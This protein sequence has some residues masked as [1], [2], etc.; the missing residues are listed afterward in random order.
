[1]GSSTSIHLP[2]IA[3]ERL[4]C[5][6]ERFVEF[7]SKLRT[8]DAALRNHHESL[9]SVERT[10]SALSSALADAGGGTPLHDLVG[11]TSDPADESCETKD[12]V[13]SYVALQGDIAAGV[14]PHLDKYREETLTYV[15][16]WEKTLST[17][18]ATELKHVRK[19]HGAFVKYHRKVE[20]LRNNAARRKNGPSDADLAKIERNESKLRTATKD[21]RRNLVAVTLLVEE[22]TDRGWKDLIPLVLMLVEHDVETTARISEVAEKLAD[23]REETKELGMRY[24]MDYAGMT[25]GRLRVLLEEDATEFV[26]PED[27]ADIESI[28]PS[29]GTTSFG[30]TSPGAPYGRM[31]GGRAPASFPPVIQ[32]NSAA[33]HDGSGVGIDKASGVSSGAASPMTSAS[34]LDAEGTAGDDKA[35]PPC[36]EGSNEQEDSLSLDRPEP[37]GHASPPAPQQQQQAPPPSAPPAATD[38]DPLTEAVSRGQASAEQEAERIR[39]A[40]VLA[41]ARL[42]QEVGNGAQQPPQSPSGVQQQLPPQL[43][44]TKS[45]PPQPGHPD[46]DDD[47]SKIN[48]PTSIYFAD[49]NYGDDVTA[50]TPYPDLVSI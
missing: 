16:E 31:P 50:L 22:V 11:R 7:R 20:T 18:I 40:R 23:V 10:R 32:E 49:A 14:G 38:P 24:E 30:S 44:Q 46:Y 42:L 47:Q 13:R 8:L 41:E 17:R 36:S 12:E 28:Q 34:D 43:Q 9:R 1:M 5:S 19:L 27:M 26:M 33:E 48:Y 35:T 15:S 37:E 4:R 21:Y 39:Q 25:A 6:A 2:S 45:P 29:I 3:D